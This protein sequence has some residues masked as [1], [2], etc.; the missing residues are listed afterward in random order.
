MVFSATYTYAL[1]HS[2]GITVDGPEVYFKGMS[3]NDEKV[4]AVHGSVL[5]TILKDSFIDDLSYL[6]SDYWRTVTSNDVC[7]KPQKRV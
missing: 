2:L 7:K 3:D 6:K 1:L 4:D 5:H